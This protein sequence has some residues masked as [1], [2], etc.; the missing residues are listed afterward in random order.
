MKLLISTSLLILT[1]SVHAQTII[2]LYPE[3]KVPNSQAVPNGEITT[4]NKTGDTSYSKVS[5]PTLE[6]Y[7]PE[8]PNGTAIIICPGGGYSNLA[9][10]KEGSKVAKEYIKWGITAFILKYRLPND[11]TIKDK[12]IG[13]LQ[14]AQ[15]AVKTVRMRASEWGIDTAKVGIA[16]FSAGGHLASTAITHFNKAVINN[17]EGINL[18]PS[19]GILVYPVISFADSLMHKGSRNKL[20]GEN[21]SADMIALYSNELQV[22][23]NTPP[24]FLIHSEDDKVVK[25]E[26]SLLFYMALLKKGVAA[27]MHIY[28]K[29]GHGFGINNMN[30][31]RWIDRSYEWLKANDL[32]K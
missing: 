1:I 26:N 13:P 16:G 32:V 23:S 25:V 22:T 24:T 7:F 31:G 15:M 19:F 9:Y 8:K 20:L 12:T 18:R 17:V 11:T 2:P 6:I 30:H 14:D 10:S 5:V 4:V 3:G 21:P 29:G 27:E 28:P